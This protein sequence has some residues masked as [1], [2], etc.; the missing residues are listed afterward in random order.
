MKTKWKYCGTKELVQ[1]VTP[2]R[3]DTVPNSVKRGTGQEGYERAAVGKSAP[4]GDME[5]AW[6]VLSVRGQV[7][8]LE[9]SLDGVA[10]KP[11]HAPSRLVFIKP[12]MPFVCVCE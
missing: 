5:S 10:V 6:R 3:T 1:S 11:P 12:V 8:S 9:S 4:H 7:K 2:L